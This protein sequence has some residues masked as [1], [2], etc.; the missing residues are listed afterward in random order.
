MSFRYPTRDL[1]YG[2]NYET[3]GLEA[4]SQ[5]AANYDDA[6]DLAAKLDGTPAADRYP[7]LESSAGAGY[8]QVDDDED[9]GPFTP[10]VTR[11]GDLNP[12]QD[13]VRETLNQVYPSYTPSPREK[14]PDGRPVQAT[15]RMKGM[16]DPHGH[17]YETESTTAEFRRNEDG[18]FGGWGNIFT[19]YWDQDEQTAH[20]VGADAET[21]LM[22]LGGQRLNTVGATGQGT[23]KITDPAT[24]EERLAGKDRFIYALDE[25]GA[26]RAVDPWAERIKRAM[27]WKEFDPTKKEDTQV[28]L[29]NHSSMVRGNRVAAA[30]DMRVEDGQLTELT[31]ISGHYRSDVGMLHQAAMHIGASGA[32]RNDTNIRMMRTEKGINDQGEEV[33]ENVLSDVTALTFLA[34]SQGQEEIARNVFGTHDDDHERATRR[35]DRG[36]WTVPEK[37]AQVEKTMANKRNLLAQLTGAPFVEPGAGAPASSGDEETAASSGNE[38]SYD[39][40][41]FDGL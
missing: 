37:L 36:S 25:H 28:G 39:T 5:D 18:T 20:R 6:P 38:V 24:G 23:Q 8:D 17:G 12:D 7:T 27:P 31:N 13:R 1:R 35:P 40:P 29:I 19:H 33:D 30:G 34:A 2:S 11:L 16:V 9:E 22:N 15:P 3:P 10:P 32:M 4:G 41:Q 26:M 14:G 21:G